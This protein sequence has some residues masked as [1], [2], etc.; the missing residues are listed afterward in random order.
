MKKLA[1]TTVMIAILGLF[2][3]IRAHGDLARPP[4]TATATA[5]PAA[6]T[7]IVPEDDD[8]ACSDATSSEDAASCIADGSSEVGCCANFQERW[9]RPNGT[10]KCC[11]P[12]FE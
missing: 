12:C 5:A 1:V 10:H 8:A 6:A 11:G 7:P 4:A 2:G 9:V 3:V